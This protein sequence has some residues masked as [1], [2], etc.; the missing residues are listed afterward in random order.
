MPKNTQRVRQLV[1]T[2]YITLGPYA[3]IRKGVGNDYIEAEV[4]N[5]GALDGS[6]GT[7]ILEVIAL[8]FN[9]KDTEVISSDD[10][11]SSLDGK[12][13]VYDV[14]SQVI[15]GIPT[16]GGAGEKIIS[17][18][19]A[20]LTTTGG[21]YTLKTVTADENDRL[22]V[23]EADNTTNKADIATNASD[24]ATNTSDIADLVAG[25]TA[26]VIVYQTKSALDASA[27]PTGDEDAS[28]KVVNDGTSSNN[29]Y[30]SWNG[31][32]FVKDADLVVNTIDEN[33][34]SDAVSGAAVFTHVADFDADSP[35]EREP[36]AFNE[37]KANDGSV[38]A[39]FDSEGTKLKGDAVSDFLGVPSTK[40]KPIAGF[41]RGGENDGD[42][43]FTAD[44]D[45][46][47]AAITSHGVRIGNLF[48][49]DISMARN[50]RSAKIDNLPNAMLAN[51]RLGPEVNHFMV[52]GRS[53]AAG[54][55][56][57]VFTS[58]SFQNVATIDG[59]GGDTVTTVSP[60]EA[61]GNAENEQYQFIAA[62]YFCELIKRK[63]NID[64]NNA[65]PY[66]HVDNVAVGGT[67]IEGLTSSTEQRI[68]DRIAST[69]EYYDNLGIKY[70]FGG[71]LFT[72][73]ESDDQM[74]DSYYT[75][76]LNYIKI[77]REAVESA[78]GANPNTIPFFL[79]PWDNDEW[80]TFRGED[81]RIQTR[82]ALEDEYVF[83]VGKTAVCERKTAEGGAPD[84]IHLS[85]LG[86][87]QAGMQ[88]AIAMYDYFIDG[89]KPQPL[90]PVRAEAYGTVLYV[91]Y[92]DWVSLE[93]RVLTGNG[94]T[95]IIVSQTTLGF[96]ISDKLPTVEWDAGSNYA[97]FGTQ[98]LV[99]K[100]TVKITLTTEIV[101][102]DYLYV[103]GSPLIHRLD[104]N[105]YDVNYAST[106]FELYLPVH[107][108]STEIIKIQ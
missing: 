59:A 10:T 71:F 93:S 33:N 31:S 41:E 83:L 74:Y 34:T 16:L 86:T 61:L 17:V 52:L 6:G 11:T 73:S 90:I 45:S 107:P 65:S 64:M 15:S 84:S 7:N 35:F 44:D 57:I 55:G 72:H 101:D 24:I 43:E 2:D 13:Y 103:S 19:G 108:S 26:G 4:T 9:V 5:L 37:I 78:T 3:R 18:S 60:A 21:G 63:N 32:I 79:Q 105:V 76:L 27:P 14:V 1:V 40:D 20:T 50:K 54:R 94:G 88:Y 81:S 22:V 104:K 89:I 58:P 87:L 67:T 38:I 91:K 66:L 56:N 97:K 42:L 48:P 102:G 62:E 28:F 96:I 36:D 70:K 12:N 106:D 47:I 95:D 77:A 23:L 100:N 49:N 92:P 99:S 82:I 53:L 8:V 98:E 46:E 25:Q 75:G 30:Y 85:G 69:K 51:T 39:R 68:V 80:D 29:G